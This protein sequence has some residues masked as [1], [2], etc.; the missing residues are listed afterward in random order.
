VTRATMIFRQDKQLGS[1]AVA[2]IEP[3]IES[4]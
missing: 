1:A 2:G 3:S 4:L